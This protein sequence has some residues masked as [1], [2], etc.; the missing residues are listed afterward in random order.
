MYTPKRDIID[1]S[2]GVLAP[3]MNAKIISP[4]GKLLGFDQ[5]GNS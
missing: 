3:N 2:C 5:E 1:G 4:Q